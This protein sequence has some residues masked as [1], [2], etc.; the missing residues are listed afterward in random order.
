MAWSDR[1]LAPHSF[2]PLFFAHQGNLLRRRRP[3]LPRFNRRGSVGGMA[4]NDPILAAKLAMAEAQAEQMAGG[5]REGSTLMSP[6]VYGQ[7]RY[8]ASTRLL[9]PGASGGMSGRFEGGFLPASPMVRGVGGAGGGG[10]SM[11]KSFRISP[12]KG[13]AG[14][15]MKGVTLEGAGK[16]PW[17]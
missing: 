13:G 8:G 17:V 5:A 1:V 15:S 16:A 4:A 11:E 6:M 10:D 7:S 12:D 2:G 9:Y 14:I 3:S